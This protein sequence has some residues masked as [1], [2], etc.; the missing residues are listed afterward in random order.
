MSAAFVIAAQRRFA[1]NVSTDELIEFVADVRSRSPEVA[2]KV[3]PTAAERVLM[4][5]F[6]GQPIDD[7][8]PRTSWGTQ[9]VLMAAIIGDEHLDDEGLDAFLAEARKLA[10]QWLA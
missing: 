4:A 6:T 2:D 10:D 7:I 1:P 3:D 8:A 5:V 9:L